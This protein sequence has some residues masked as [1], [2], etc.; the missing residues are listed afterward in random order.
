MKN[1][2]SL[3]LCAAMFTAC[4]TE[5]EGVVPEENT[6]VNFDFGNITVD[7]VVLAEAPVGTPVAKVKIPYKDCTGAL[8]EIRDLE[9]PEGLSLEGNIQLPFVS[10]GE[11]AIPMKNEL[12]IESVGTKTISFQVIHSTDTTDLSLDID[13]QKLRAVNFDFENAKVTSIPTRGDIA[14]ASIEIPY[15]CVRNAEITVECKGLPTGLSLPDTE[16]SVEKTKNEPAKLNI[17]LQRSEGF[18]AVEAGEYPLNI[19]LSFEDEIIETNLTL[20]V[21]KVLYIKNIA[22]E[23]GVVAGSSSD[24]LTVK[25]E[26]E[27]AESGAK[28]TLNSIEGW[29]STTSSKELSLDADKGTAVFEVLPSECEDS[30]LTEDITYP[31]SQELTVSLFYNGVSLDNLDDEMKKK[32]VSAD[33]F[34]WKNKFYRVIT[35]G[36]QQW[37]DRNLGAVT[38]NNNIESLSLGENGII[39]AWTPDYGNYGEFYQRGRTTGIPLIYGNGI[40]VPYFNWETGKIW[41]EGYWTASTPD[42]SPNNTKDL[43]GDDPLVME[44]NNVAP[45]G[46]DIPL[47]SDFNEL[48]ETVKTEIPEGNLLSKLMKS[49]LKFALSGAIQNNGPTKSVQEANQANTKGQNGMVGLPGLNKGPG[50]NEIIIITESPQGMLWLFTKDVKPGVVNAGYVYSLRIG[51]S[52]NISSYYFSV[53]KNMSMPIRCI[54]RTNP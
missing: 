48:I 22:V 37:L 26:Y 10:E 46:F 9:M 20:V 50:Q 35:V 14:N 3:F 25:V 51:N 39:T 11:M 30:P 36:S 19:K 44:W 43:T 12:K 18:D 40:T 8:V 33:G 16:F 45:V 53:N 34:I 49:S 29:V 13:I 24:N 31:T 42:I 38:N 27:D 7:G 32:T 5:F 21:S 6:K 47:Q 41:E 15:V 28:L 4:S 2:I 23:G 52:E 1:I 54:K 17:P